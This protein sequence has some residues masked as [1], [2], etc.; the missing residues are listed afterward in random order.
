ML[1]PFLLVGVGGS[2]GKTLRAV[3]KALELKLEQESWQGGWPE[4]WQFLHVDTPLS[5]DGLSFP[6]PLL[7][8]DQYLGLVPVGAN[9]ETVYN[10]ITGKIDP[11]FV[12]D[13]EKPLPSP[14]EVVV[15]IDMGAG[16]FRAIGRTISAASLSEIQSK[17]KKA[18]GRMDTAT[19]L[20]DLSALTRFLGIPE[21]GSK[22]SPTVIIVSSI[23]GGS[24]AGQFIDVAEA[25]KSASNNQNWADHMF[26]ILYA[27]DVFEELGAMK[28]IA[29]NSLG[30][31]SEMMS[32]FWNQNPSQATRELFRGQGLITSSSTAYRIG[33]NY[34]Y[35]IGRKNGL[36]DFGSQ[37]GVYLAVAASVATWITDPD[38][39]DILSAYTVANYASK[40]P[41][42]TDNTRLR[43][44][45]LDA[46]PFSSLG[47]GRVSLG[48]EKFL[49]YSA[50]RLAKAA[51]QNLLLR[52][53][54]Q[55]PLFGE[56]NEQQWIQEYAEQAYPAFLADSGLNELTT[57]NDQIIGALRPDIEE[58][59]A[60]LNGTIETTAR[61]GMPKE[62]HNLNTWI[63]RILN[64]FENNSSILLA[65]IRTSR[66][67]KMR[68]WV[69][70]MP[71]KLI[72]LVTQTS[73]RQGLPVTE[74]LLRRLT[75]QSLD[76]AGELIQERSHLI[77]EATSLPTLLA[78][79]MQK[80]SGMSEIKPNNPAVLEA[81]KQ[82][83]YSFRR[84]AEA[85]LRADGAEVV[86]DLISNFIEPLTRTIAGAKSTLRDKVE[87][88]RLID[89]RENP[90]P[91]W[92]N[93]QQTEVPKKFAP[94]PN[95]R[96]LVSHTDYSKLFDELINKTVNDPRVNARSVVLDEFTMG[97]Y[98]LKEL[99]TLQED[100]QWSLI[101]YG[102]TIWIPLNRNFQPREGA[103]QAARF[104]FLSD[105]I[106]YFDRAKLWLRIPGRAFD[107][108]LK[109]S[110]PD[111]MKGG[112]DE[113]EQSKRTS[114]FI[115][116][117]DSA[118]ASSDPLV[119]MSSNLLVE[120]HTTAASEKQTVMSAIPISASDPVFDG[121][122]DVLV[123]YKIWDDA[124]SPKW[125][126]GSTKGASVKQI[127]IFSLTGY[128]VQPMVL[129]SVMSPIAQEWVSSSGSAITRAN[130]MQWRRGRSLGEA[131][132]AAPTVWNQ[133]LRGWFVAKLFSQLKD[134]SV[135]DAAFTE[136]GPKIGVWVDA[137]Q[138]Y[139][140]FP[141]PLL[142]PN[143]S[144]VPDYPGIILESLSIAMVNCYVETSLTPLAPYHR[145]LKLGGPSG[146][147]D[148][149]LS[150][151][152]NKGLLEDKNAPKVN[153][154]RAGSSSDSPDERKERCIAFF[155]KE[156]ESFDKH[157]A[158]LD[159]HGDIRAY[160]VS[161]E[162]RN[163]IRRA[164]DDIILSIQSIEEEETL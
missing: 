93:F 70:T 61:S 115:K 28:A 69:E 90:Y 116:E 35:I 120:T 126:V 12:N 55:D 58:V 96:L 30:A 98:G 33:P 128:P 88:P 155:E 110:I 73:A 102:E 11:N 164:I 52:H 141:Y 160:P 72:T 147:A 124:S 133:M 64:T 137:G 100:R 24:G 99:K 25:V 138:R 84:K 5:Q 19:A 108:F 144:P 159:P 118:V 104:R 123:R 21:A 81:M 9:Y 75:K 140:D 65:E 27:P 76:A 151:W 50:E 83:E 162:I 13:V 121:L 34:P 113:S 32:G 114:R 127:D 63:D 49:E 92:P 130:F 119:E 43:R 78:Q 158:R 154:D 1:R 42:L 77:A 142:Y 60:K 57:D 106:G 109:Q 134:D 17:A 91:T 2:G 71:E 56:K 157:M 31:I 15:P 46:A 131:I 8:T 145:L 29:P 80:A 117:F 105:Q 3:R 62:G 135:R 125:F 148:I 112:G 89:G 67:A 26:S 10:A 143:I 44:P 74:E 146:Q 136:R 111:W 153:P 41:Q 4:A 53:S 85:D 23:A 6:A 40:A 87:D 37:S 39:Q 66:E 82:A 156:L 59:V 107:A 161:W 86:Q 54:E 152:I 122:K 149:E 103:P 95:E 150:D 48:L 38:I 94:A 68:V 18:I 163:E 45:G 47:F 16:A 97:T 7:P 22:V 101:E 129:G 14:K 139:A 20:S 51:V 36:V 79:A 132:P